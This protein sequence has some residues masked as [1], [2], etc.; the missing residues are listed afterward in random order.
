MAPDD[1]GFL[2]AV[3]MRLLIE[4]CWARK[5]LFYGVVKDSSSRFLTRNFLGVSLETGFHPDLRG[6]EIGLLPWTD[7]IFCETLP[8]IDENL[9]APWC[10]IEFDAAFMTLHR[11][12]ADEAG[13]TRVL[14][15][16]GWIV[17]QERLFARSLA[18]FFLK[19]DKRLPL[20]GHVVFLERLLSPAWDWLGQDNKPGEIVIDTPELGRFGAVAWRDRD[21]LNPGQWVMMYLLSVL[22]KNHYAEAIGYPDPLHKADWG[23]KTIGRTVGD[24][25]RSSTQ[26]LIARPLS[27]TFR[28]IR[29]SGRRNG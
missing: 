16:L 9:S 15:V 19:R 17:N 18:Q 11:E 13:S 25:I 26:M 12:R 20:A 27:R 28:E 10:T 1:L 21:H 29:D 8:R 7:R 5:I 24:T 3:G 2:I 6:L 23:A 4:E 14:G 22:T